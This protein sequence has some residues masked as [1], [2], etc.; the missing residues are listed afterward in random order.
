[1]ELDVPFH[2]TYGRGAFKSCGAG[3]VETPS[4]SR[5][6][7]RVFGFQPLGFSNWE[8]AGRKNSVAE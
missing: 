7:L 3:V 8:L 2:N 6:K 1:M 5:F 4:V